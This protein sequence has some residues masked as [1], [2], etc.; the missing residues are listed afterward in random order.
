MSKKTGNKNKVMKS[1][2][3]WIF[4]IL[5]AV[6]I[7][8]YLAS[9]ED[10]EEIA[11]SE[12]KEKVQAGR[13][14]SVEI[15]EDEIEGVYIN[16]TGE[17]V[18]FETVRV[19]DSDLVQELRDQNVTFKGVISD[20][21]VHTLLFSFGPILLFILLWL[22]ILNSM[23]R[24]GRDAMK[25]GRAK[26]KMHVKKKKDDVTFNDV[27]GMDETKEELQEIV[28]Y[29]KNPGKFTALGAKIPKGVL[30]YGPPGTGKTL[31]TKAVAG[32][33]GV[34]F[35]STSGSEFVEMFVGVGASRIRDLFDKGRRSAPCIIFID[36]LDAVGRS[37]FSGLGGGHDERE[38]TLN[39][40]LK[41]LDG[42]DSREGVILIGATNRP[43]V[44]DPA[45]LRK[46]RFDRHIAVPRPNQKERKEIFELHAKEIKITKTID[47]GVLARR[48]PGFTGSDIANI[49]NESALLAARDKAKRVNMHYVEEAIDRVL[50]GPKKK[51]R[52]ISKEEKVKIAYHEAGHTLVAFKLH[53]ADPVHKVSILSRGTALGYTLQLPVEDRHLVSEKE[54]LDKMAVMLGGRSAEELIFNEKTTGAQDDLRKTTE[55]AYKL[56]AEYGMS[57]ELGLIAYKRDRENIFLG[58]EIAQGSEYSQKTAELIDQGAKNMV[59]K[60][61]RKAADILKK[62]KDKLKALAEEL[63]KREEIEAED[64]DKIINGK[65]KK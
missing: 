45:L 50:A 54:I 31:L 9:R 34:P 20:T 11:Y 39:Q 22:F 21:W 65:D 56:V 61:H 25:F 62:Y 26:A 48:T 64:I 47:F 35:F 14:S 27:A 19:D 40:I 38:Q 49:I 24:G 60:C 52:V 44:L 57:E 51:S 59:E 18:K 43:D 58:K 8:S 29:L 23:K 30:L 2:S 32:E 55:M 42:F 1:L 37:R 4:L 10:V 5:A 16:P 53:R 15:S 3:F 17:E 6:L 41:E 28:E 33:A 63:V 46:G 36:E 7:S 12:F 13:I